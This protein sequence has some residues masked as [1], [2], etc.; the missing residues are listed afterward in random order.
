MEIL[1]RKFAKGEISEEELQ[2]LIKDL[3]SKIREKM[4]QKVK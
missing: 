4:Q 1:K 2:D 3:Y